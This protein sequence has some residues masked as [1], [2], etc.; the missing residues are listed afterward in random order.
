MVTGA[1]RADAALIIIDASEGVQEQTRRHGYLLRLIGVRQVVIVVNKMDLVD[2]SQKVFD[3]VSS[4]YRAVPRE[5]RRRGADLH[6]GFRTAGR[7][8][9]RARREPEVVQRPRR[10][11]GAR[12][13]P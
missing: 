13:H 1:A 8:H 12:C 9:R 10:A 6:S 3:K 4:E 7:Q 11:R 5:H 2:Y